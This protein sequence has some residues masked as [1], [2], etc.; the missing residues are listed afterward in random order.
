MTFIN[1]KKTLAS[2]CDPQKQDLAVCQSYMDNYLAQVKE[3]AAR[4]EESME[5]QYGKACALLQAVP[6]V[7]SL[8]CHIF[9]Q[10]CNAQISN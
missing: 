6:H 10:T 2:T 1:I 5:Q 7:P 9:Q 4:H 8:C 3:W